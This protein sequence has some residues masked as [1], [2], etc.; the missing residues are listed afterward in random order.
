M[1]PHPYLK[2]QTT[3]LGNMPDWN[4]AERI[5]VAPRPLALSLYQVLIT[6]YA[7][8]EARRQMGYRDVVFEPLLVALAGIPY[9]HVRASF[10]SF[11]P[12]TLDDEIAERLVN[13]WLDY[14]K[15]NPELHDKVEFEVAITCLA[16]DFERHAARL[17]VAGLNELDITALRRSLLSLTDAIL[18][19]EVAS[20]DQQIARVQHLAV[21][22]EAALARKTSVDSLPR[23]IS[24]LIHDCVRY[25]TIP[26]SILARD[27]FIAMTFMK[28]LRRRGVFSDEEYQAF[29]NEIPTVATDVSRKLALL[30]DGKLSQEE[31]V[32]LY[33]HLRPGTYD[34]LSPNYAQSIHTFLS[35]TSEQ[36]F[37]SS[38][39]S[40][41]D[42]RPDPELA[43]RIFDGKDHRI[44][45]LLEE[46]G[47][48]CDVRTLLDFILRAI[49][50]RE[51]AKF[52]FTKNVSE[53]L[54]LAAEYGEHL[55]LSREDAS[56]LSIE[57]IIRLATDSP[58]CA[59][60]SHLKR[61]SGFEAKRH[62]LTTAIRLPHLIW[63]IANIDSFRLSEWQPN[64]ITDKRVIAEVVDLQQNPSPHLLNGRIALIRS[65]DPG[66]D[67]IFNYRPAGLITQF[68]GAASHMAI[69]AA[70]FGLPSAIG[71]GDL[72][73]ERVRKAKRVEIDCANQ[74]IRVIQ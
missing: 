44:A 35:G 63:E 22:R 60:D 43:I 73:F 25:G 41:V 61:V 2:G 47:F 54:E 69:R 45:Q 50:G 62:L 28:S 30:I 14:L 39:S 74:Q 38:T 34:I 48:R 26:F 71:C 5:G 13:A 31:F 1:Q 18:L 21:R 68:G 17:R 15:S 40:S 66:Y 24:W 37:A 57:R 6:D 51:W 29:L 19:G 3:L 32:A 58:S 12:A 7:W 16:F 4:P 56:Y 46:H 10:T 9:I 27:A 52:E 67:W 33:G 55:G 59:V 23:I 11:L 65:A 70:E 49:P 42:K 36:Q 53:V 72:I 64:F 8:A 20:I